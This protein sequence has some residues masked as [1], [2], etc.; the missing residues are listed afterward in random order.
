MRLRKTY[1]LALVLSAASLQNAFGQ[2]YKNEIW[3][4]TAM[5][6]T[7]NP[8]YLPDGKIKG[9]AETHAIIKKY[10][11]LIAPY[12][13][14]LGYAP[15]EIKKYK[16]ESPLTDFTADAMLEAAQK[17]LNGIASL[18]HE[19]VDFSL[20]NYGGIRDNLPKGDIT[21][22]DVVCVFPFNNRM[23]I[24]SLKGKYVRSLMEHFAKSEMIQIMGGVRIKV[25]KRE[26]AGCLIGGSAIDDDKTYRIATTDYILSGGDN[27][28]ALSHATDRI[29]TG[30]MLRDIISDAVK[31]KCLG[32]K[33][34][35]VKTDGRAVIIK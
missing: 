7:Y 10:A 24:V 30:I 18:K 1:L 19:K 4:E 27:M 31:Q 26:L 2:S 8:V 6:S 17:Y 13:E 33:P 23:F 35:I 3:H 32:G 29:D 28:K 22:Y 12:Y 25:V 9:G 20:T 21:K 34:L 5:D 11:P 16:P 14:K 15:E